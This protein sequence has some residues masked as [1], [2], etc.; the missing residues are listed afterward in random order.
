MGFA[1]FEVRFRISAR[2]R[3]LG[4]VVSASGKIILTSH[5][6]L[7][8]FRL[9]SRIS[10]FCFFFGLVLFSDAAREGSI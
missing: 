9:F 1:S 3:Y 6:V 2:M 5:T 7:S 10:I 4:F 8:L